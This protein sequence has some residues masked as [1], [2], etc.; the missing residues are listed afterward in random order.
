MSTLVTRSQLA[1]HM[2][3]AKSYV[4]KLGNQGRLVLAPDGR[5]EL[6]PTL[7]LIKSTTG[8][9]ERALEAVMA[10]GEG[11]GQSKAEQGR[12]A[13]PATPETTYIDWKERKEKAQAELAEMEVAQRRSQLL[14]FDAVRSLV[15]SAATTLRT[16]LEALPDQLAPTLAATADEQQV[17]ARLAVEIES[18]LA[19]LSHQ[20]GKAA[21][22]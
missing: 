8:A 1:A 22:V 3:C 10:A 5:I 9:P 21:P 13:A 7:A 17:R 11:T 15:A 4:T 20:L 14:E 2:D 16:R 19:D 6:E 12:Q 18:A